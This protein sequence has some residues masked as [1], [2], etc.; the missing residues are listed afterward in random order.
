MKHKGMCA[1][2]TSFIQPKPTGSQRESNIPQTR[3][4]LSLSKVAKYMGISL[5]IPR[6]IQSQE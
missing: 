2:L 1:K 4:A 3:S 5:K 6:L